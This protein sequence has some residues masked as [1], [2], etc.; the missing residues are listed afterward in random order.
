MLIHIGIKW[1]FTFCYSL[2]SRQYLEVRDNSNEI[3]YDLEKIY[4]EIVTKKAV[5][6]FRNCE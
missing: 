1:F 2:V 3:S 4:L 5:T 6:I